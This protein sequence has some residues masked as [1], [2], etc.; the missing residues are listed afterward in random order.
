MKP[1]IKEWSFRAG[2]RLKGDPKK[3]A[4]EL[5]RIKKNSSGDKQQLYAESV[6][7]AAEPTRSI[8]HDY[9]EWDDDKAAQEYRLE[10]ARHLIRSIRITYDNPKAPEKDIEVK[11]FVNLDG[12]QTNTPEPYIDVATALTEE[13]Y[14]AQ[15]LRN[16]LRDAHRWA[17]KYRALTELDTIFNAIEHIASNQ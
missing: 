8:L 14:R 4:A 13:Q 9:F 7:Q 11:L 1:R 6:V 17:N 2:S 15:L 3:V 5:Q 16:A 10:Q 12:G